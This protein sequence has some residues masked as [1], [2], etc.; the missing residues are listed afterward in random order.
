MTDIEIA[1]Q[2]QIQEITKITTKYQIPQDDIELY[3]Q[4]KA[5][6]KYTSTGTK[7]GKLILVTAINPTPYGEG[8]TTVSIGLTDGLNKLGHLAT[9][10][11]RQPSLG[12]VFGVKGGATGGGYSQIIP[13]EDINLHFTG[14]FHAITTANNLISAAIDNHIFQGNELQIDQNQIY[15][16]RCLDMND[17]AL[18]EINLT[19]RTESFY[20]TAAS[21]IMSILCLAQ[22]IQDLKQKL[23]N[24]LIGFSKNNTPIYAKDLKLEGALTTI[25]KDAINP[26]LV[27]TL[28]QNLVFLHGGPFANIAHGCNSII[29]TK[30]ALSYSDYT[31]TEAGFGSDL[32][33]EKFFD[34][35]CR[36]ANLKPNC[37][38]LV[39]TIKALKHHDQN[40]IK[41]LKEHLENIQKYTKNIVVCLNKFQDDQKEEINVIK[42]YCQNQQI[43]FSI[44]ES[45]TQG[46]QGAIELASQVVK[47]CNNQPDFHYL[48]D[49]KLPIQT[50]IQTICKEIYHIENITYSPQALE[51]IKLLPQ[52]NLEH[53]EIC[54]AKN[55]YSLAGTNTSS[56]EI[57]DINFYT[58]AGFITII[59]GNILL[60]PGLAKHSNY[61][62]IDIDEHKTITGIF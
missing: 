5:K 15:F 60:M 20:I 41:N 55:Q 49:T 59:T 30:M 19:N 1:H 27:Q 26:N 37:I 47:I 40:L 44:N 51:K 62:N 28:E 36:R 50:K 53:A 46:G 43:P 8:K 23:Q 31:I 16:H 57:K 58:G 9:A 10:A 34:I 45:Y 54:I 61:E 4:Y 21:E 52:L 39:A 38:V 7:Q 24:I 6:I 13:M 48:Y 14:D 29:A 22:D 42:N 33:A 11:L 32:G 12:P 35:K 17:R 56:L 2:H 18:R 25:L 3:G